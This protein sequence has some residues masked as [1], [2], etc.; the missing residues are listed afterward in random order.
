MTLTHYIRALF[1]PAPQQPLRQ[2]AAYESF[3]RN[4]HQ[5]P[6]YDETMARIG[7]RRHELAGLTRDE[8][9]TQCIDT[10]MDAVLSTPWRLEP[11]QPR[12]SQRLASQIAPHI[13]TIVRAAMD[14]T[15]YGYSVVEVTYT[16]AGGDAGIASL[17]VK[18]ME[19][20]SPRRDADGVTTWWCEVP[21]RPAFQ[22]DP[23]KFFVTVRRGTYRVPQGDPMLARLWWPLLFKREGLKQWNRFLETFG[24]P[25]VVGKVNAYN[26]FIDAMQQQGV[27]SVVAWQPSGPDESVTTIQSSAPGEFERLQ[28]AMNSAIQKLI[29]G[30]T[31]TSQVGDSGSYA[32]AK[33]HN[34]VRADKRN[35]DIRMVTRLAQSVLDQLA[36]LNGRAAPEFVMA[37]DTGL[38]L[39]RAQRDATLVDKGILTLTPEY[40]LDRYDYRDGDFVIPEK[41]APENAEN[42]QKAAANMGA[43][44]FSADEPREFT[45]G[46]QAVE[47]QVFEAL[48]SGGQPI[49]LDLIRDA[50]A[51]A[52]DADDLLARLALLL[53]KTDP[54]FMALLARAQFAASVLGYVNAD[55]RVN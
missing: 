28:D 4:I 17:S 5:L 8:E 45:P 25:I 46:Q 52:S 35:A 49:P 10:R 26:Q 36:A 14:A 21:G 47:S 40:L 38:E 15:L 11:N 3:L 44:S 48:D 16:G 7:I 19:W 34:E 18:P 9:V 53:D 12:A 23:R 42:T 22:L 31:L 50:I 37:D 33:V 51:G 24:S 30:Q 32:A 41:I 29:L 54:A 55:E 20:F 43:L 39:E 2:E 27:R 13:E 6:D 1:K